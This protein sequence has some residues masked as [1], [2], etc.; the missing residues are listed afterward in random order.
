MDRAAASPPAVEEPVRATSVLDSLGAEVLAVM[1]PVSICMALVVLLISLLSPPSSGSAAGSPP[2]VTAATLVYLESPNDS[3]GQKLLGALLDAAV[4]VALVAAVTFVLVA[5]YYYRCTGFLKN[6]MRFSAF[7]VIFSMGGAIVAAVLRR[8]GAPLDAATVLLLLFNGAAVG[9]LSVFASA[10]PILV[11]QG[12]MVALAA[13]VAAWLSRLPEWTTWIMLVALALYDLVAVLAPRGPLR[14]LV[15]L[16]S[17]RDDELPALVY[18]SRPTVGPATSSSS[19]ASVMGSVEMQTMSDSG[20]ICGNR[21][22]RVEQEEYASHASLEMRDLGRGRSSVGEMNRPRG[23]VLQME[24]L[25]REVPATSAELTANQGGGSQHAIIQIEQPDEEETSPLVSAPSTNTAA[26][27]VEEHR[28]SS[29]SEPLDF[30]MFESTRGI[31]LGLGD[32]VFYSVLVGRAAMYD[33]M[34]VY[35]CYL[36]IIAGLGCT[37]I[38]LSICRHALPAL[39]ISIMLGVTFYFL[40]RLLM[41][42]FVVGAST[43]LVM[44]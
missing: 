6:Y 9:V 13:I 21:Y 39:P 11:R 16:A 5:L 4:F 27:D 2:P 41:E 26:L 28:Q 34:T 36:A 7:F 8:L 24:N 40:T 23:P 22:D 38:L 14:M 17:S 33:L 31:K 43:N 15:E 37:L 32:F 20:Q 25:E 3:P 12:Y 42:P 18:E 1:S 19:Y 35:A 10:V 29:S 30:E 44:F